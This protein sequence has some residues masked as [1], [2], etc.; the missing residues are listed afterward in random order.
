MA[1]INTTPFLSM[2]YLTDYVQRITE[3]S[4]TAWVCP[5]CGS[6]T[7][8]HRTGAFNIRKDEKGVDRWKCFACGKGGDLFD[9]IGEVEGIQGYPAQLT[10]AKELFGIDVFSTAR[11]SPKKG[12]DTDTH[13]HIHTYTYTQ[14]F[15][16]ANK[17]LQDAPTMRGIKLE[18]L[19]KYGVG[20]VEKWRIPLEIYLDSDKPTANGKP[21]SKETWER[22]PTSPRLIVPTSPNSYLARDVRKDIPEA[23]KAYAKSKVGKVELFNSDVLYSSDKPVFVTEGEFDALSIIDCGADA[24]A[25]GSIANARKLVALF[26]DKR[27]TAKIIL[28][29]DNDEQGKKASEQLRQELLKLNI[30]VTEWE[31]VDGFKDANEYLEKGER[32]FLETAITDAYLKADNKASAEQEERE[33]Y[34]HSSAYDYLEPFRDKIRA[35]IDT[36]F[37]STGYPLLDKVFDGGLY[38]GLYILG[39][40]SSVGKTTYVLQMADQIAQCGD[41]QILF[42]CLEMSRFE[43]MAKS[44][45]RHTALISANRYGSTQYAKT[46]RGVTTGRFWAGYG[47]EERQILTDAMGDYASYA[48]NIFYV[49]GLGDVGVKEIREAIERHIKMTGNRP[50]C[51]LDYLQIVRPESDR[52]TD[53]QAVDRTVLELKKISRDYKLPFVVVSSFNRTSYKNEVEMQSFKESGAIEY[54]ADVLLGLQLKG[55]GE[56]G[57]DATKEKE[58][59]PRQ[60]EVR[61]LKNRNGAVGAKLGYEYDA[62]Y[63]IYEERGCITP[64]RYA[65]MTVHGKVVGGK[66][67]KDWDTTSPTMELSKEEQEWNALETELNRE[68][69]GQGSLV[70]EPEKEETKKKGKRSKGS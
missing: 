10:R 9:L 8:K 50:V 35:S 33:A 24:C 1:L 39:A 62:R 13:T 67:F 70:D 60:I 58:K 19:D 66:P 43:M 30:P 20:Y 14:F 52:L 48:G 40:V 18:T 36:P 2:G 17:H 28:A 32:G 45:S 31:P 59:T 37:Y 16:D 3:R 64:N 56:D 22:I 49:E 57:F 11:P 55:T 47:E 15:E 29:L 69:Q 5:L 51:F 34:L 42:F 6:G 27:P 54:S 46:V 7:G 26:E 53:K 44:I 23:Q 25:L 4:G 68:A 38:E 65:N 61:I 21:R 63:N 41:A 12:G